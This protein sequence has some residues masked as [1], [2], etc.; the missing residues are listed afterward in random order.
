M[1]A[2]LFIA[3]LVAVFAFASR[4]PAQTF[5]RAELRVPMAAAGN[6]GLEALLVRPAPAGRYPLALI[7]HGSPRKASTRPTM[8]V[9]TYQP[10]AAEFARRGWA[11]LVVLRRGYGTSGGHFSEGTGGCD[12][13]DYVKAGKA[14]ADDLGAAIAHASQRADVDPSRIISV[15][16]SAGGLGT[17]ALTA[18]PP[19]GLVA[20][21]SFAGGRGSRDD[22]DV[23]EEDE[24]VKALGTFGRTSRVPMLWVYAENDL[25]F[26]PAL[27]RRMHA[28]FTRSGGQAE[29]RL[30]PP[31]GRDGHFLFSTAG[32]AVWTPYVDRFLQQRGLQ[33]REAIL[34]V[35][36]APLTPPAHLSASGRRAFEAYRAARPNKAFAVASDGSYGW[37]SGRTTIDEAK[38]GAIE[39]CEEH[40][41]ECDLVAVNDRAP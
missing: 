14:T 1:L 20:A 6:D 32:I 31:Y 4:A 11:A 8:K 34:P 40:A 15:G 7:T 28:A 19:P 13:P 29:F 21:I 36:R 2:R 23:C 17:V 18:D 3:S 30:A 26:G 10:I 39:N 16:V 27:A 33:L 35:E 12:D 37:R 24:L 38:D 5:V 9:T 25:F 41:D 22:N